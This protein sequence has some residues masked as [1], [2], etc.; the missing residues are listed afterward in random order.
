MLLAC[1]HQVRFPDCEGCRFSTPAPYELPRL[2]STGLIQ[3]IARPGTKSSGATSPRPRAPPSLGA[4]AYR[5]PAFSMS[6]FFRFSRIRPSELYRERLRQ[7]RRAASLSLALLPGIAVLLLL[8]GRFLPRGTQAASSGDAELRTP[9][10]FAALPS[11]APEGASAAGARQRQTPRPSLGYPF[12]TPLTSSP[13]PQSQ[14]Q[15]PSRPPLEGSRLA[16]RPPQPVENAAAELRENVPTAELQSARASASEPPLPDTALSEL[17]SL[18]P[19]P[20]PTE[21]PS[22]SPSPQE[23]PSRRGG[24][25]RRSLPRPPPGRRSSTPPELHGLHGLHARCNLRQSPQRGTSPAAAQGA[26]SEPQLLLLRHRPAA[27]TKPRTPRPATARPRRRPTPL[28]CAPGITEARSSSSSRSG[29]TDGPG[30]SAS[31]APPGGR[32]STAR[33][34]TGFWHTE[35][36]PAVRDGRRVRQPRAHEHPLRGAL[37]AAFSPSSQAIVLAIR[38]RLCTMRA[39]MTPEANRKRQQPYVNKLYLKDG[40]GVLLTLAAIIIVLLG[41]QQAR[42]VVVPS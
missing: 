20:S 41:L 10:T 18:A 7:M 31:C 38:P 33:R 8:G 15:T 4:R 34:A 14:P 29:R 5:A 30:A 36:Y 17:L 16:E 27:P 9:S 13:Q 11:P 12:P 21:S 42:S 26:S 19:A 28:P 3:G 35:L 24:L 6:R 37:S 22:P 25:N 23:F 39:R 32:S 1:Q 2:T 40:A